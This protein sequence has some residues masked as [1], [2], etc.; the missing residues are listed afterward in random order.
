MMLEGPVVGR[1][2]GAV[3][4]LEYPRPPVLAAIL[5]ALGWWLGRRQPGG[6]GA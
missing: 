2:P 4:A 5:A 1:H 6:G 3:H